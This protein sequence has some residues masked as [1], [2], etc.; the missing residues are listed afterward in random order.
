MEP[1]ESGRR[2]GAVDISDVI[3]SL[4]ELGVPEDVQRH[5]VAIL[6]QQQ[7]K[8]AEEKRTVGAPAR[9]SDD[10]ARSTSTWRPPSRVSS[11]E[12][13]DVLGITGQGGSSDTVLGR[14]RSGSGPRPSEEDHHTVTLPCPRSMVGRVIGRAGDTINALQQYTNTSIQIDQSNDPTQVTI[15]G[16]VKSVRMT[17]AM[18]NDII[19]GRFK[20]F[21][22]L[23][24]MAPKSPAGSRANSLDGCSG[25][26]GIHAYPTVTDR[27]GSHPSD[28]ASN[29]PS[30]D[31]S[32]DW[33][34]T[35]VQGYGFMPPPVT[36]GGIQSPSDQQRNLFGGIGVPSAGHGIHMV[37]CDRRSIGSDVRGGRKSFGSTSGYGDVRAVGHQQQQ[38]R[39]GSETN[40]RADSQTLSQEAVLNQLMQISL[41]Q[42]LQGYYL[43]QQQQQQRNQRGLQYTNHE[44]IGALEQVQSGHRQRHSFSGSSEAPWDAWG[45]GG[46]VSANN[47]N[48]PNNPNNTTRPTRTMSPANPSPT[49]STKNPTASIPTT[50]PAPEAHTPS[51]NDNLS[52][53]VSPFESGVYHIQSIFHPNPSNESSDM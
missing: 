48:N 33:Q 4:K 29:R 14:T 40:T 51:D 7:N 42:S 3:A 30:G 41:N 20:G 22:I 1:R 13:L 18:V 37:S 10:S 25:G 17:V 31:G 53:L 15:S 36:G 44:M 19:N 28:V 35:Y 8:G 16:T 26:V 49:T 24:Q 39:S 47:P 9:W 23:R 43:Y 46:I 34:P 21:A 38:Y 50:N 32:Q 12:S 45:A 2:R 5:C 6:Q 27:G 52:G 11:R